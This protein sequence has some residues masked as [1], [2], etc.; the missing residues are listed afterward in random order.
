M[1]WIEELYNTYEN[2]SAYEDSLTPPFHMRNNTHIEVI[3]SQHGRFLDANR[4]ELKNTVIPC[5]EKSESARTMNPPPH[6]LCD[7]IQFVAGDYHG[8]KISF[9]DRYL[10]LLE[11][12]SN[13]EHTHSFVRAVYHYV[14]RRTLIN[15]LK[16]TN[17][18]ILTEDE[19]PADLFIRW[20]IEI[21]GEN[22]TRTWKCKSLFQSW[23]DFIKSQDGVTGVCMITGLTSILALNHAKKIRHSGDGAKLI[24]SNDKDGFTF[25]GRFSL[26]DL[27]I[28]GKKTEVA[29]QSASISAEVS[30]KAHRALSW[31]I[32]R[33]S[34]RN[35]DQVFVS[36][37][38]SGKKIPDGFT[39]TKTL[40]DD[41][42]TESPWDIEIV[43]APDTGA[44]FAHKL[45]LKIAGYR[46]TI[47]ETDKIILMGFDSASPG[48][49]SIIFYRELTGSK[50]LSRI[51]Q[52]H[53][54]MAWY[55]Q[56]FI[57]INGSDKHQS[58]VTRVYAPHPKAIA[59][60]CFG[61]RLDD[62]LKKATI[63]RIMP[64]IVDG[65]RPPSDLVES[66]IRRASN[67]NGIDRWDWERVLSTACALYKCFILRDLV[68]NPLKKIEMALEIERNDRD[69]LYG[70]LL[71]V[72]EHLEESAL[73]VANE[74]RETTAARLMQRFAEFPF[75]TWRTIE[76]ALVPYKSRLQSNRPGK[77]FK[78]KSLLDE[79][80]SQ[81]Q[82][83]DFE[84]DS[85]LSGA[86]L[87]GYHC[88]RRDLAYKKPSEET[89]E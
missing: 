30:Q 56:D 29:I 24:S 78:M 4:E 27:L 48:R 55:F 85:R 68:N 7:K 41:K 46:S 3:I 38:V 69:Y 88:Q 9:F 63:E 45:S 84:N 72:A 37:A 2:L 71:A 42:D 14:S 52:W 10:E 25:R 23:A 74:K 57:K 21:P 70:R 26:D 76:S 89:E 1:S 35:G 32:E 13:S 33:Q 58:L 51:E 28:G 43:N 16:S 19:D 53:Q 6:P 39:D 11:S 62:K 34:F 12:W 87:L 49:L 36:W 65:C 60:S 83:G 18:E 31:L 44:V 75:S 61:K 79:I 59:E 50:F 15:D 47:K 67:R 20:R 8:N 81:F 40:I 22:E 5:T 17:K 86:Y 77:L 80:H 66:A 64:C 82:S 73:F 54:D